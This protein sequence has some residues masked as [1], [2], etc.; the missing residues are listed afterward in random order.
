MSEVKWFGP[1]DNPFQA[2]VKVLVDQDIDTVEFS[3]CR[4]WNMCGEYDFFNSAENFVDDLCEHIKNEYNVV[5]Q[6]RTG[7]FYACYDTYVA[8]EV[9][10]SYDMRMTGK[11][12]SISFNGNIIASFVNLDDAIKFLR[13]KEE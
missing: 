11:T 7:G 1:F 12:H 5:I 6:S 4:M 3:T 9:P 10:S 13:S 8:P 2:A